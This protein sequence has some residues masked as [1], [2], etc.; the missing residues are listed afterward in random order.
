MLK[1]YLLPVSKL[2]CSTNIASVHQSC[3]QDFLLGG[4]LL[5]GIPSRGEVLGA[6]NTGMIMDRGLQTVYY[7]I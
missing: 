5:R 2:I 6:F 4:E 1:K 3:T 7:Y